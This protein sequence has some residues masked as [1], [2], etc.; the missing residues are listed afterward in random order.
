MAASLHWLWPNT[1]WK[2]V[3][4]CVTNPMG[5]PAMQGNCHQFCYQTE[6]NPGQ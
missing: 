1:Q 2:L 6:G 5:N 3:T 4:S